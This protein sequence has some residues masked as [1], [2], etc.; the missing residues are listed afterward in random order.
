MANFIHASEHLNAG[1]IVKLECDTQCNFMLMTDSDFS[2]YRRGGAHHYY[3]GFFKRFPATIV[4]PH[5][6]HWNVVVDL[7]GG[8]ANIRYSISYIKR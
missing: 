3:G 7:G 5:T 6:D 2:N 1:S 8:R 4:V